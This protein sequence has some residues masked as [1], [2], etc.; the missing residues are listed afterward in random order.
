[1][2]K[3][4]RYFILSIVAILSTILVILIPYNLIINFGFNFFNVFLSLLL[5]CLFL[6]VPI[7]VIK[8]FINEKKICEMPIKE[9]SAE[10]VNKQ[11]KEERCGKHYHAYYLLTFKIQDELLL[12]FNVPIE[13]FNKSAIG[14]KGILSYRERNGKYYFVF[15]SNLDVVNNG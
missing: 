3:F 7:I 11:L 6:T 5:S 1:M 14:Q 2:G 12:T 8:M 13:I 10:V 15:F 4:L 9:I